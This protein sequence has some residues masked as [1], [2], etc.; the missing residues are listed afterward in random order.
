MAE[1]VFF[2]IQSNMK[3]NYIFSPTLDFYLVIWKLAQVQVG[4]NIAQNHSSNP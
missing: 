2:P 1:T 4:S 3:P